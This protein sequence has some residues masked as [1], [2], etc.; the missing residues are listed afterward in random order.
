[1]TPEFVFWCKKAGSPR[2][3]PLNFSEIERIPPVEAH[4]IGDFA[5]G[6]CPVFDPQSRSKTGEFEFK[7]DKIWTLMLLLNF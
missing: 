1:M 4:Q 5:S 7:T 3:N 2:L 6:K